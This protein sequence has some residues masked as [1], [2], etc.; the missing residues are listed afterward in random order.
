M[1]LLLAS[2]VQFSAGLAFYRGAW[3]AVK[4]GSANM[5]VLVALG[6][7]A[8]FLLSVVQL[9]QDGPLYFESSAVVI[10][11][12]LMYSVH[13]IVMAKTKPAPINSTA[14]GRR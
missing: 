12:V 7:S 5:D 9:L 14:D 2:A 1:N 8:A 3:L 6:T 11:L 10:T 13:K 4:G